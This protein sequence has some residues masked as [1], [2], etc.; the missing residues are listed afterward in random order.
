MCNRYTTAQNSRHIDR[1]M[2]KMRE[3]RGAGVVTV[4]H[5][6]TDKNPADLF[7]KVLSRQV[8]EKHRATVLNTV[9]RPT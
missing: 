7:T 1:K 3:L 2:F 5:V 4:E 8:F 6:A 9:G